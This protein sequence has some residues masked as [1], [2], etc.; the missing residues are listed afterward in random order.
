[1]RHLGPAPT[2]LAAV[3]V[4]RLCSRAACPHS[5]SATLTYVYSDSTVVLGPLATYAEPHA[6]DLC[7]DHADRLTVPRGWEVVR[8]DRGAPA[9]SSHDDLVALAEVVRRR[10][11][12]ARRPAPVSREDEE[13]SGVRE[14]GRRGHLRVLRDPS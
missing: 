2:N 6:Y 8:L 13:S 14:E 5:A 4:S 3:S 1:M 10:P 11:D 7:D 12:D 9:P